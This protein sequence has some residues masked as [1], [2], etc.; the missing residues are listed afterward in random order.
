MCWRQRLRRHRRRCCH[1][2]EQFFVAAAFVPTAVAAA[3]PRALQQRRHH[4][5]WP[6]PA[7]LLLLLMLRLRL[8]LPHPHPPP[9]AAHSAAAHCYA[10]APPRCPLPLHLLAEL[11]LLL[12][13][14]LSVAWRCC[15]CCWR[16]ADWPAPP[17]ARRWLFGCPMCWAPENK[18]M[19]HSVSVCQLV[20]NHFEVGI[21]IYSLTMN[22]TNQINCPTNREIDPNL[23]RGFV[24]SYPKL[25]NLL[26]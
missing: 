18:S 1:Q 16:A 25:K 7:A 23:Q 4:F 14:V 3:D 20:L 11:Q 10:P 15:C 24:K 26:E 12:L 6:C 19:F 22:Q 13:L 5:H 21:P 2:F 17:G 9:A 8:P